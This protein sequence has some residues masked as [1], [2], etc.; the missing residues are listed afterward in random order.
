MKRGGGVTTPTEESNSTAVTERDL[1]DIAAR[2]GSTINP[3]NG[4][5]DKGGSGQALGKKGFAPG[6]PV[7]APAPKG[8]QL[9]NAVQAAPAAASAVNGSA[10]RMDSA[11]VK[12]AAR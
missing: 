1:K 2:R 10:V 4:G 3:A 6:T 9:N 5:D 7:P 11:R 12:A 8:M